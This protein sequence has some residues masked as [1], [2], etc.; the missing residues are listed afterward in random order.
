M[1]PMWGVGVAAVAAS[2]VRAGIIASSKGSATAAPMP[3]KN[4]RRSRC[5]LV[6][7]IRSP[8]FLMTG[9]CNLDRAGR[10]LRRSFHLERYALRDSHHYRREP[11]V[12]PLGVAHNLAYRRHVVG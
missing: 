2:A 4:V 8:L 11:V 7:N 5:F 10:R 9:R 1:N 3:R 6:M 12:V